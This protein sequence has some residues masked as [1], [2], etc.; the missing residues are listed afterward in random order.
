MVNPIRALVGKA[1]YSG[2]AHGILG[3]SWVY[4]SAHRNDSLDTLEVV[5]KGD[6]KRGIS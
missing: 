5:K 4:P 3:F 1:F 2:R 6:K